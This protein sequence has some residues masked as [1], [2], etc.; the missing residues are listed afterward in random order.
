MIASFGAISALGALN[1]W[2]MVQA[3]IPAAMAK[4][5]LFP[6][7][8]GRVSKRGIPMHSHLLSSGL[9]SVVVQINYS[10]SMA[11]LFQ[12]LILL[13][14]AITL[15][16]YF[17]CA[18][19]AAKLMATGQLI[20]SLRLRLIV[21]AALLYI[22]FTLYGAGAEAVVWGAVLLLFGVPVYALVQKPSVQPITP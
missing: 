22:P 13:T 18:L 12:F 9:L 6:A 10:K 1:G 11:D 20:P 17:A 2:L 21:G 7:W 5:G 3:E 14:T 15:V 4:D 8:L 19:A 16:V